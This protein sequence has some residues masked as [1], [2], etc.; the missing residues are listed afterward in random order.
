MSLQY[1]LITSLICFNFIA[2]TPGNANDIRFDQ[3]SSTI[4]N[5]N[6]TQ[7]GIGHTVEGLE[8]GTVTN[9]PQAGASLIGKFDTISLQQTS[10]SD[11]KIGLK[12][13]V[14]QNELSDIF[15][16]LSGSGTHSV[17]LDAIA[18]ELTSIITLDGPGAKSVNTDVDAAGKLVS[19]NIKLS[20]NSIDLIVNQRASADLTVDLFSPSS[21]LSDLASS[22]S[23]NQFG[24]NSAAHILGTISKN[25]TLV[26]DQTAAESNYK[27][28]VTLNPNSNLTFNQTANGILSGAKVTLDRGQSMTMTY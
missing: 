5:L 22:V 25:A 15:I 9:Q 21:F 28:E 3:S 18:Q 14:A 12:V 10:I 1:F 27:L 11:S 20:G 26:F 6:I 23:I 2:A 4:M 16:D 8:V 7:V 19:H 24:E 17:M 13:D